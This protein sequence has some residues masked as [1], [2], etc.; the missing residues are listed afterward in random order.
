MPFRSQ[1]SNEKCQPQIERRAQIA[2]EFREEEIFKKYC[3][4]K[5]KRSS[6]KSNKNAVK[7]K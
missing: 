7:L 1:P 4:V 2:R 6:S 5:N 3:S